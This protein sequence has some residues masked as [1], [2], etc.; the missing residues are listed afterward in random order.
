[1]VRVNTIRIYVPANKLAQ[2]IYLLLSQQPDALFF[3]IQF[4]LK[5]FTTFI[6]RIFIIQTPANSIY[7]LITIFFTAPYHNK[8]QA[9]LTNERKKIYFFKH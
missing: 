7:R 9:Q 8:N 3:L 4:H 1:M 5:K 2:N 6:T